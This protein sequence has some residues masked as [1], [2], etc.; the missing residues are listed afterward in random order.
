MKNV[1]AVGNSNNTDSAKLVI[2]YAPFFDSDETQSFGFL[3]VL[4]DT[5]NDPVIKN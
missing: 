5:E 2:S 4:L 3:Y 1:A